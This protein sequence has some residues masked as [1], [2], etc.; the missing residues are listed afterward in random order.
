MTLRIL[1]TRFAS[2]FIIENI[3]EPHTIV[4]PAKRPIFHCA[5]TPSNVYP[6]DPG[7]GKSDFWSYTGGVISIPCWFISSHFERSDGEGVLFA[8]IFAMTVEYAGHGCV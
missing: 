1:S 6:L 4:K 3:K 5:I 2:T 7:F 8:H